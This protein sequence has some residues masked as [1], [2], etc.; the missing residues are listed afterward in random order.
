MKNDLWSEVRAASA[1]RMHSATLLRNCTKLSKRGPIPYIWGLP[2][3]F[4]RRM[5]LDPRLRA[6]EWPSPCPRLDEELVQHLL[7]GFFSRLIC[8]RH[9]VKIDR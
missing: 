7:E 1:S 3:L 4:A 5:C 2:G 9:R 8:R 6:A